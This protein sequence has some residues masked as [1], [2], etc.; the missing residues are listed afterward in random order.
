MPKIPSNFQLRNN[1]MYHSAFTWHG[2]HYPVLPADTHVLSV[3]PKIF[4][5]VRLQGDL[6]Y[7]FQHGQS[8]NTGKPA[9]LVTL[10][11]NQKCPPH[12]KH[13]LISF[14]GCSSW[15][16]FLFS[17]LHKIHRCDFSIAIKNHRYS[18]LMLWT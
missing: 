16:I 8:C 4:T 15:L 14:S 10:V 2:S 12:C 13:T 3:K 1:K 17:D 7:W 5:V 11:A 9:W 6:L 18:W